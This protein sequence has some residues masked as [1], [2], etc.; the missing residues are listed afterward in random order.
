MNND[1]L[2]R[3]AER[4]RSLEQQVADLRR[5]ERPIRY[6]QLITG[7]FQDNVAASQSAV[8]LNVYSS[9]GGILRFIDPLR[10][11]SVT[12]VGVISSEARTAGTLTVEAYVAG[13]AIG[14]TAILNATNTTQVAT[15]AARGTH[16]FTA[17]QALSLRITTT[18]GWLPTTAD[19]RAFLEIET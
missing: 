3:M 8:V 7:F 13:V 4:L 5:Q 12:G 14:L 18:A 15:L 17:L 10:A 16:P 1:A 2:R 6:R 11:G 19:I 9:A